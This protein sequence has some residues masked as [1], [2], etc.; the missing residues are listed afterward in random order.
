MATAGTERW[1][2]QVARLG[3]LRTV[4]RFYGDDVASS[5]VEFA[6]VA[7]PFFLVL[8][9]IFETALFLWAGQML[10]TATA[11]SAR[12]ILT[13][14]A[15]T[16]GMSKDS[17]K[18]DLCSHL[19]GLIDCESGVLI[20]V[21]TYASWD[22]VNI[23]APVDSSG[24]VTA[25][26]QLFQTGTPGSIQVVRAVYQYPVLVRTFGFDLADLANGKR[27]LVSTVAFQNEPYATTSAAQ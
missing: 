25:T 6:F 9:A 16:S 22:A 3:R 13:G 12:L 10:D 18:R 24:N 14:Q 23:S 11:T 15:Q 7:M 5:G 2:Q 20:D 1:R 17:F 21:Q 27:L 19:A 26:G 4:R 8:F